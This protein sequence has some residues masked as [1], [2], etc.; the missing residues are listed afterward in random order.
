VC[1]RSVCAGCCACVCVFIPVECPQCVWFVTRFY[2]AAEYV[3]ITSVL[4]V[5][6]KQ[7]HAKESMGPQSAAEQHVMRAMSASCALLRDTQSAGPQR[8]PSEGP[9][10]SPATSARDRSNFGAGAWLGR[11]ARARARARARIRVRVRIRV[12]IRFG[13]G[14]GFG[15]GFKVTSASS[16]SSGGFSASAG[17]P[18][19]SPPPC[20]LGLGLGLG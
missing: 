3:L 8:G 10:T 14:F 13:F 16:D 1:V 15:F 17:G 12:Y 9:K 18:A 11:R 6:T 20:G 5:T 4:Q 2:G 7:Q 19:G